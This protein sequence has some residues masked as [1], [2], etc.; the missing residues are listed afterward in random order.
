MWHLGQKVTSA[1]SD[2]RWVRAG[3]EAFF[4]SRRNAEPP[5]RGRV[6]TVADVLQFAGGAYLR[7]AEL[8]TDTLYLAQ[9]FRPEVGSGTTLAR[10]ADLPVWLRPRQAQQAGA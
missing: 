2:S 10:V 5:R 3:V 6:Y 9:W 8:P 7:L 4:A 1:V